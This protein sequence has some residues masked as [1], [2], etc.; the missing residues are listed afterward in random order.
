MKRLCHWWTQKRKEN[1]IAQIEWFFSSLLKNELNLLSFSFDFSN[2]FILKFEGINKNAL[3]SVSLNL[4]TL[5]RSSS[6]EAHPRGEIDTP[7]RK[8][9]MHSDKIITCKSVLFLWLR[10]RGQARK[11]KRSYHFKREAFSWLS[12]T[13]VAF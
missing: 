4:F 12:Y 11:G 9:K 8:I 13:T 6:F 10:H 1:N 3:H 2:W 5:R 7:P